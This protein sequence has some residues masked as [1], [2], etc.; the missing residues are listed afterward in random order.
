MKSSFLLFCFLLSNTAVIFADTIPEITSDT[1]SKI[2][3]T[4]TA[5]ST[6]TVP[7]PVVDSIASS[8]T[9]SVPEENLV[10][11]QTQTKLESTT[12]A[13][14]D[15]LETPNDTTPKLPGFY[16]GF[17]AGVSLGDMPAFSMW[18]NSLPDTLSD[19]KLESNS[20]IDPL[21]IPNSDS[22]IADTSNLVFKLK[23][24]P[25]VYNMTF[26]IRL[27]ATKI[28]EKSFIKTSL[29]YALIFKK[30]K[31]IV[32]AADDTLGKRIDIK[33]NLFLHSL[34]L[35][36]TFGK[37]IPL[38]YFSIESIEKSYFVIGLGFSPLLLLKSDYSVKNSSKS[39][40]MKLVADA[41]SL[42]NNCNAFG[43]TFTFKA[44]ISSIKRLTQNGIA[45][46][47]LFYS[48]NLFDYFYENGDRLK[49]RDIDPVGNDS[50]NLSFISNRFE[51]GVNFYRKAGPR[52]Q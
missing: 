52:K 48:L 44:G 5:A 41:I 26:P 47:G 1:A 38:Q 35:D 24:H 13:A 25:S 18:K 16:L 28:N 14:T 33:N 36:L 19:L 50:K 29:S 46:I 45:E 12:K 31:S 3:A 34:S 27:S 15:T 23:E 30:Q 32:F 11:P 8:T 43:T 20:F 10:H 42:S 4:D 7:V 39:E 2:D 6:H 40:R 17:G 37:E 51:L 22:L 9:D 21:D 49:K